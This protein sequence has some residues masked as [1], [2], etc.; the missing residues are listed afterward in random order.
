MHSSAEETGLRAETQEQ[1]VGHRKGTS[2][3]GE[4]LSLH[5][6]LPLMG[7][8]R[9]RRVGLTEPS[10]M[11]GDD[12]TLSDDWRWRGWSEPV[13]DGWGSQLRSA[14]PSYFGSTS[15]VR[16]ADCF[17]GLRTPADQGSEPNGGGHHSRPQR[18][19]RPSVSQ[20]GGP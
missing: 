8:A 17:C 19:H 2:K 1:G 9:Q 11:T 14:W 12:G 4:S 10:A 3:A 16:E 18:L 13:V 7:G 20:T 6:H 15:A 5:K